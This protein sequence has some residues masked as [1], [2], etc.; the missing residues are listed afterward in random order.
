M[1]YIASPYSAKNADGTVDEILQHKRY[2]QAC[3]AA[4]QLML[5]MELVYS[6]IAHWHIIDQLVDGIGYEDYLATDCAMIDVCRELHVLMLE[7]WD[8]SK[9]VLVEIEY[10]KMRNKPVK[11][12][13]ISKE[14][15]IYDTSR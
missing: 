3:L 12:F 11:Y 5:N 8:K 14:G 15:V 1:I 7:G 4:G 6:P 13:E 2:I 10:A 9:G